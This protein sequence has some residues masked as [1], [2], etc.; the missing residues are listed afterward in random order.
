MK[1]RIKPAKAI[2]WGVFGFSLIIYLITMSKTV[3]FWDCGEL[4]ACADTLQTG[5]APGAPVYLLL[6]RFFA[7]FSF[8]PEYTAFFI[9]LLSAVAS[10]FAIFFTY[11][12]IIYFSG[13]IINSTKHK[14]LFVNENQKQILCI[15]SAVAGS[16]SLAFSTTFW[17]SAIEAEVYSVSVFF[18]T[19]AV[20]L[21]IKYAES[22][23]ESKS[24]WLIL[25]SL[26]CGISTGVHQLNILTI[27]ALVFF[28]YF[29]TYDFSIK[30]FFKTLAASVSLLIFVQLCVSGIPLIASKFEWFFANE[31]RLGFN[32]GLFVFASLVILLLI[33]GIYISGIKNKPGLNLIITAFAVFITGYSSYALVMIRSASNPPLDQNNPET[34]YN[35]S[36]YLNREQYGNRPLWYGQ[37][38]NSPYDKINPYVEGDPVYDTAENKYVLVSNKPEANYESSGKTILPRMWSNEPVHIAAYREWTGYKK[39]EPPSFGVNMKFL[40]R[41][42]FGHMY[43]RYF[44]WNF[45][46]RQNDLLS[47]GG[48]V[49]GNWIS[50]IGFFDD[51][52]LSESQY[53]PPNLDNNR[54]RNA[55]YLLPLIL[56]ILGIVIQFKSDKKSLL[57]ISLI[58]IFTG[59]AIAFYL[60]QHPYQARERDYSYI[61]SFYAFSLWIGLGVTGLYLFIRKNFNYKFL[62]PAAG[63]ICIIAV[64]FMF[65][66][67]NFAD[68]NNNK[69]DFARQFAYNMLNSCEK[70]AILFVSG[71]NETFPLWYLQEVEHIRTDVRIVNLSF[72]N[73][74]WYIDQIQQPTQGALGIKI[75]IGKPKYISGQRELLMIKENPFGFIEDIY[76]NNKTEID[77]DYRAILNKFASLLREGGFDKTRPQEFNNFMNYYAVIEPHGASKPFR[78]FCS[79]VFS[80]EDTARCEAFGI[81]PYDGAEL[82]N[83]L[84][85]FLDKQVN[86]P[87]NLNKAL[88][89]VFSEDSATKIATKLY[90]YPIDYFP[91]KNLMLPINKKQVLSAFGEVQLREDIIV[92]N[93][94]WK[95]DRES[96]TKSEMMIFEIIRTNNWSRPIYFSSFMPGTNYLGLEKYLYLE[97]LAYRLIPVETEIT[98]ED[99]V[100]VNPVTMYMNITGK[101]NW[102][103]LRNGDFIPDENSRNILVS[104]RNHYARLAR[105]LYFAGAAEESQQMLDECI[106]LIP[107][108]F[109]PFEYYTIGIVHGYYRINQ[110]DKAGKIATITA[111]NAYQELVFYSEFPDNQRKTLILYQQRAL[112]TI[113]E[114]YV[115]ADEYKHKE[116]LPG[117]KAIYEESVKL[118]KKNNPEETNL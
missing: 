68:H 70:N 69:N 59:I 111:K 77:E 91:A 89:F 36:S 103:E 83:V 62:L 58:F 99:P 95:T 106:S 88:D 12:T 92:D 10:S 74:D 31:I 45:A 22:N 48:P 61:G 35:F 65:L 117:L 17:A 53:L 84:R 18:T 16:L 3:N 104:L 28:Y 113:E 67:K 109:I 44:M 73:N 102:G 7:I 37:Q 94:I 50:G 43:F 27:P 34:I 24:R 33:A 29:S 118:Y 32:I 26:V 96:L 86:Y 49:N 93:M 105:S 87:I 19:L 14:T 79:V 1:F 52:R 81:S 41:Y 20:W 8:S 80:L 108:D 107:N 15:L 63:I 64:P 114:L 42:Q 115:L 75:S 56:G 76:A 112:K 100:N 101:F 98:A 2:P 85:T 4:I 5:H 39:D 78:E 57:I 55:Y 66:T 82:A 9:N 54:S 72:L 11:H 6:A 97:G 46:G 116:L 71:D 60:N 13:K 21:M 38:F 30:G 90:D 40:F 23:P 47:H 110:K 51:L 25:S